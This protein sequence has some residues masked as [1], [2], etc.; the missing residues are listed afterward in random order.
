MDPKGSNELLF[1]LLYEKFKE[2]HDQEVS[3]SADEC[4]KFVD[5]LLKRERDISL[6]PFPFKCSGFADEQIDRKQQQTHDDRQVSS[7]TSGCM[8]FCYLDFRICQKQ[9]FTMLHCI[10]YPV[11]K[12][13]Q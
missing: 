4:T 13:P 10:A 3:V 5:L 12:I 2:I 1:S 9:I 11:K 7:S 6:H 8:H